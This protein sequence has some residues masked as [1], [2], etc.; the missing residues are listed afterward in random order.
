MKHEGFLY[1]CAVDKGCISAQN[2]SISVSI[3]FKKRYGLL[4][5]VTRAESFSL[6]SCFISSPEIFVNHFSPESLYNAYI[7]YSRIFTGGYYPFKHRFTEYLE[8]RFRNISFHSFSLSSCEDNCFIHIKTSY[9]K[10]S[11][12]RFL[13]LTLSFTP[14][15]LRSFSA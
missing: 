11:N 6:Q 2:E 1:S 14:L 15:S 7:R 3:L 9:L 8:K 4:Y 13:S 5:S 12:L 10:S